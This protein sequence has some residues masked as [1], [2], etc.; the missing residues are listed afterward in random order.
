VKHS[1]IVEDLSKVDGAELPDDSTEL[2]EMDL[3]GSERASEALTE[4]FHMDED[5][6]VQLNPK[7]SFAEGETVW[8]TAPGAAVGGKVARIEV[9]KQLNRLT[10][11]VE[12]G[13][14]VANYPVTIGSDDTPSPSGVMEVKAIAPDPT[15][16]YNP[17]LKFQQGDNAE[18][19]ELPLGP[20]AP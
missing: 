20:T 18:F 9:Q 17:D 14:I 11:Y 10:A 19:L 1:I 3:L 12:T 16:S 13:R 8:V 7:P 4:Q 2:A 15:Y 6:L 5:F